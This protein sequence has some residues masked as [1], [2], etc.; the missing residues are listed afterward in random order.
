MLTELS[1]KS[2]KKAKKN[3]L[4]EYKNSHNAL[5]MRMVDEYMQSSSLN[6]VNES[7]LNLFESIYI[8]FMVIGWFIWLRRHRTQQPYTPESTTQQ[9]NNN[10]RE[11]K[12]N[13]EKSFRNRVHRQMTLVKLRFL[14]ARVLVR[15]ISSSI[16]HAMKFIWCWWTVLHEVLQQPFLDSVV[17]LFNCAAVSF[18]CHS[19]NQWVRQ[20]SKN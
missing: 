5:A 7:N 10:E 2:A 6:R 12:R 19:I 9:T 11:W 15:N 14:F 8:Y 16:G 20:T 3:E 17:Y 13:L 18:S 4:R 1:A